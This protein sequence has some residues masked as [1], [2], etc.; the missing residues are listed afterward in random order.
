[1]QTPGTSMPSCGNCTC[2]LWPHNHTRG[3]TPCPAG[4]ALSGR[5]DCKGLGGHRLSWGHGQGWPLLSPY[6]FLCPAFAEAGD[7]AGGLWKVGGLTPLSGLSYIISAG[8]MFTIPLRPSPNSSLGDGPGAG[9]AHL[10]LTTFLVCPE[11]CPVLRALALCS[12]H[13]GHSSLASV[14]LSQAP[15]QPSPCLGHECSLPVSPARWASRG[16]VH[17]HPGGCFLRWRSGPPV[18]GTIRGRAHLGHC[19]LS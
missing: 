10:P 12:P 1:M 8:P 17:F 18:P 15:N 2:C 14:L 13:L 4:A 11:L 6:L 16:Q 7:Q 3:S 5:P 9:P 19:S